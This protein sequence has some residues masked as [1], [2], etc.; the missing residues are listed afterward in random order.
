METIHGH[1]ILN[2][3][4][5]NKFKSK[6]ELKAALN[7]KFGEV[8]FTNCSKNIYTFEEI[9]T[10]FEEKGKVIIENN[11]LQLSVNSCSCSH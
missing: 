10:F 11:V 8:N 5:Q 3:L 7:E 9:M 6:D 2:L 4:K 1:E